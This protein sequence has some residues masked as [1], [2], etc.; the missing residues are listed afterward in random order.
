MSQLLPR[1][2]A[3]ALY[4]LVLAA[5]ALPGCA[6]AETPLDG[7]ALARPAG[8]RHIRSHQP[9]RFFSISI[10][11]SPTAAPVRLRLRERPIKV[12]T[13]DFNHD[14][15]VDVAALLPTRG[16]VLFTRTARGFHRIHRARARLPQS[17]LFT[18]L[19]VSV[20]QLPSNAGRSLDENRRDDDDGE[21]IAVERT[22]GPPRQSA[23]ALAT[24]PAPPFSLV[25]SRTHAARA[26][27]A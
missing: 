24:L 18:S 21:A 23:I 15:R 25:V 16:V 14:G 2:L 20:R 8:G 13:T 6:T 26:P 3:F 10:T 27:P 22:V 19:P 5:W 11:V 1:R 9:S 4:V 17:S 12:V 7:Q